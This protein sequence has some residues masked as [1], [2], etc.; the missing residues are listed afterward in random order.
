MKTPNKLLFYCFSENRPNVK[1]VLSTIPETAAVQGVN[2]EEELK[3]R[4]AGVKNICKRVAMVGDKE[5]SLWTYAL[6]AIRSFLFIETAAKHDTVSDIDVESIN[7]YDVLV[8]AQ[9]C[10]ENGDLELAV[11]FMSLLKGVPR[12]LASDWLRESRS[13]LEARLA[14]DFLLAYVS[15]EYAFEN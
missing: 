4:F 12:K 6:S 7:T 1:L 14:S 3:K 5:G 11:K 10:I 9:S 13:Y 15:S 8:K 2:T